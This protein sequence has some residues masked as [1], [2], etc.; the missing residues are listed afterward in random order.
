MPV[1]VCVC[2]TARQPN[3]GAP[4]SGSNLQEILKTWTP[5]PTNPW[6]RNL[7]QHVRAFV[8]NHKSSRK[9][10]QDDSIKANKVFLLIHTTSESSETLSNLQDFQRN[11]HKSV[12]TAGKRLRRETLKPPN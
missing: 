7:K 10:Q 5:P 6:L 11:F 9:H 2:V 3:P 4:T 1:R 8:F 12:D